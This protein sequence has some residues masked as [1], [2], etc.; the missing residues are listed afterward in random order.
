MPREYL[1]RQIKT[2]AI[3]SVFAAIAQPASD[4]LTRT[5]HT[6]ILAKGEKVSYTKCSILYWLGGFN[7]TSELGAMAWRDGGERPATRAVVSTDRRRFLGRM[8]FFHK[9]RLSVTGIN[10]E[11]IPVQDVRLAGHRSG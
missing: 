10:S 8:I 1:M 4:I 11:T 9:K 6:S 2:Q 5:S 7:S 3:I